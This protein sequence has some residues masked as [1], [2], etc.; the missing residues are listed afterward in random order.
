MENINDTIEAR[1]RFE[2]EERGLIDPNKNKEFLIN[3]TVSEI[4]RHFVREY[5]D[6]KEANAKR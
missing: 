3:I 1:V 4:V 5:F 2:L 6:R